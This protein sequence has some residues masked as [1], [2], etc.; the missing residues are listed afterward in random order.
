MDSA[1]IGKI[2]KAMRYSHEPER[3]SFNELGVTFKGDHDTYDVSYREGKWHCGC[4]FFQKRGV[5]SHTMTLERVLRPMIAVGSGSDE[6]VAV[7]EH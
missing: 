4:L 2:E 7:K 6:P 5:C 3:I 1:M